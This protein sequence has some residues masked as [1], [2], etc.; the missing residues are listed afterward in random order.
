MTFLR[1]SKYSLQRA[2]EKIENFFSVRQIMSDVFTDRDPR[3]AKNAEIVQLGS[4]QIHNIYLSNLNM[5]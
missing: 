2:K 5:H 3:D 1:G 4:V